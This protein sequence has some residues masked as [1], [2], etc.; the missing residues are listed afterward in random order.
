MVKEVG[1]KCPNPAPHGK[2]DGNGLTEY[3]AVMPYVLESGDVVQPHLYAVCHD[4]FLA[5]YFAV[6]GVDPFEVSRKKQE[7]A[8][9][10]EIERIQGEKEKLA[11]GEEPRRRGRPRSLPR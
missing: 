4:C 1:G 8:L 9:E 11:R 2:C 6:Y 5:Q 7:A 10:K 3:T